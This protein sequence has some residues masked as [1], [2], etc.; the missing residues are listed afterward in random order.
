MAGNTNLRPD[1][2]KPGQEVVPKKP[3]D[4]VR[5]ELDRMKSQFS[6]MLPQHIPVERFIRTVITAINK[7]PELATADRRTLYGACMAACNDGLLPDGREGALVI[8][9]TK[10]KDENGREKWI[11]AVQW[12]P[13]VYGLKKKMRQSGE[14]ISITSH[15]VYSK[16]EF[17]YELGDTESIT[18]KPYMGDDDPGEVR[19]AYAIVKLTDGTICRRVLR[20][21]DIEKRRNAGKSAN[22][23]AWRNWYPEMSEVKAL[24]SLSKDVP[25]STEVERVLN[26]EDT[27]SVV[28]AAGKVEEISL[29]DEGGEVIDAAASEVLHVEH[30]PGDE[31]PAM[32]QQAAERAETKSPDKEPQKAAAQQPAHDPE[33]GEVHDD[34]GQGDEPVDSLFSE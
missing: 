5:Y 29:L 20:R 31:V 11:N 27:L 18:H 33:T 13:M 12:M 4:V 10:G 1:L 24:R 16:D 22:S 17:H 6:I 19:A 21:S 25:M 28:S 23:P 15:A 3:V 34:A 32:Q 9:N 26:R 2:A 7:A 30:Q 8:F 14:V